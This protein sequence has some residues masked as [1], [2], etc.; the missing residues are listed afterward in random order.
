MSDS[1]ST[2]WTVACEAPLSLRFPRQEFWSGLP[3]S[4]PRNLPDPGI[5]PISP[6]LAGV[7]FS[8]EPPKKPNYPLFSIRDKRGLRQ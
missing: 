5:K 7:F 2:P 8:A 3:F 4:H 6:A 1:F